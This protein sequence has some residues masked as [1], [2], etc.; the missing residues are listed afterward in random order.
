VITILRD[1]FGPG[2]WGTGG[3]MVAW[4]ICGAIGGVWLRRKLITHHAQ[5]LAQAAQHHKE[6]MAQAQAHHEDMKRHVAAH[7]SDIKAHVSAVADGPASGGPGSNPGTAG[8]D[9]D[10]PVVPPPAT[11]GRRR[12]GGERF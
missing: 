2:T 7:C 9:A 10:G 1:L 5:V 11:T 4:V 3:N 12:R 6:Q 8:L